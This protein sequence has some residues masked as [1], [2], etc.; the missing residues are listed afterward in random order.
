MSKGMD[1][2]QL[3]LTLKYKPV[4]SELFVGQCRE[5]PFIIVKGKSPE[6]LGN[7]II[8]HAEVYFNTF[9]EKAKEILSTF[10]KKVEDIEPTANDNKV[11]EEGQWQLL[12][13]TVKN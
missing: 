2:M 12:P 1:I 3:K 5:F 13:I 9:P 10:G 8:K 6:D 11:I 4:K 7:Q